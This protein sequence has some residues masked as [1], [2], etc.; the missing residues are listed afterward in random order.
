MGA[1]NISDEELVHAGA[2]IVGKSESGSRKLQIRP[3][4]LPVY[5]QLV[6][7]KLEDG[8]WTDIVGESQI[9]FIFKFSDGSTKRLEF[10][11]ETRRE[12]A[13]SCSQLNG[14]PIDKTSD[15]LGYLA[16]NAFYKDFISEHY[17]YAS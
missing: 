14:D 3:S 15:V 7:E 10:S 2:D 1:T 12:I 5:E 17:G 11:E 4:A 6:T 13:H 16:N 9:I 8:F